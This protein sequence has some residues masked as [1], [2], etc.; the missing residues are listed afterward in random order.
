MDAYASK[1]ASIPMWMSIFT[2]RMA[3]H[4]RAGA[5][6]LAWSVRFSFKYETE[7]KW[8]ELRC[9]VFICTNSIII[10]M[11][12]IEPL[13][14]HRILALT[15]HNRNTIIRSFRLCLLRRTA[16]L[17]LHR[18]SSHIRM[19]QKYPSNWLR[20]LTYEFSVW[21]CFLIEW[22]VT[23]FVTGTRYTCDIRRLY[24][25]DNW[26]GKLKVIPL[27]TVESFSFS[28]PKL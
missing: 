18:N 9:M 26:N 10:F 13:N 14:F 12:D 4:L 22:D 27:I 11:L 1:T 23:T 28:T 3:F 20:C 17:R 25:Q 24:I 15:S 21:I 8:I 19:F 6:A 5:R 7:N 16:P 2:V